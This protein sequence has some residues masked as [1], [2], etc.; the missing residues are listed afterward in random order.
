[1]IHPDSEVRIS[2]SYEIQKLENFFAAIVE[3]GWLANGSDKLVRKRFTTNDIFK[4]RVPPNT[5]LF[6]WL[7]NN[8][9]LI[10]GSLKCRR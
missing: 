6:D 4:T 7:D 10:C 2:S 3:Q 1:M 9:K 5:T 8:A